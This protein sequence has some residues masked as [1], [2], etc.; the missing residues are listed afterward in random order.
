M[1]VVLSSDDYFS[2]AASRRN[3]AQ[4]KFV[5]RPSNHSTPPSSNRLRDSYT[6][7]AKSYTESTSSS[8]PSSPRAV[9]PTDSTDGSFV[10]TPASSNVSV[11]SDCDD[12]QINFHPDDHFVLPDYDHACYPP[13]TLEELEPP[14]SPKNGHSYTASPD[15]EASDDTSRPLSPD[16]LQHHAEDDTAVRAQPTRH[17]DY[18]SHSWSE[19]EIW[20]SWRYITSRRD[21][22]ANGIRLE[23]AAWRTWLKKKNNLKTITPETLNW[24]VTSW[25]VFETGA[26]TSFQAQRMRRNLAVRATADTRN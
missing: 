10:S 22:Y 13:D 15:S 20:L 1:A 21:E 3:R 8:A 6:H 5:S 19:E 18:L 12:T 25:A 24:Y 14:P 16:I 26:L 9:H 2:S 7:I 23:N 17:V 4:N 11:S